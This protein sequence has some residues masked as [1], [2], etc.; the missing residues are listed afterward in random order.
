MSRIDFP[1]HLQ[2]LVCVALLLPGVP[3]LAAD[4]TADPIAFAAVT[5]AEPGSTVISE[6]QTITGIDTSV[7]I[8][9]TGGLYSIN[10]GAFTGAAGTVTS[11]SSVRLQEVASTAFYTSTSTYLRLGSPAVTSTFKVSTRKIDT[12]PDA[13]TFAP[14]SDAALG[15]TQTSDPAT[16]TGLEAA[17]AITVTGGG[18]SIDGGE[19]TTAAGTITNNAVVRARGMAGSAANQTTTVTVKIGGISGAFKIVTAAV[20]GPDTTP[21]AFSFAP[22]ADAAIGST[23]TSEAITVSGINASTP[24]SIVGGSYSINGQ[25]F[26]TAAGSVRNG[27]SVR[28]RQT[29]STS[30]S[31]KTTAVLTIGGVAGSW[32]L[33][34]AALDNSPD[35]IQFQSF[36]NLGP[37]TLVVSNTVTVSGINSAVPISVTGGSYSIDGGAWTSAS[38]T[39][40]N[41]AQVRVQLLTSSAFSSATEAALTISGVRSVFR[42]A[43]VPLE[44]GKDT[45]IFAS[46]AGVAAGALVTSNEVVIAGVNPNSQVSIAGVG[47]TYSINGGPFTREDGVVSN[48]DTVRLRLMISSPAT[49]ATT[50]F[51]VGDLGGSFSLSTAAADTT[52]TAFSLTPN[53]GSDLN[54]DKTKS[55]TV[56][57]INAASPISIEGG[58]YQIGGGAFT[59]E[60]G[61]VNEGQ[62]VTVSL[63]TASTYATDTALRVTI[64]GVSAIFKITTASL[65]KPLIDP[66]NAVYATAQ[67]ITITVPGGIPPG[68]RLYYTTDRSTPTLA[69]TPYTGPFVQSQTGIVRAALLS[70]DGAVTGPVSTR[71]YQIYAIGTTAPVFVSPGTDLGL[72]KIS[73]PIGRYARP[74][75]V[76]PPFV[77]SFSSPPYFQ[78]NADGSI[79]FAAPVTGLHS[80][81]SDDPRS[82]LRQMNADGSLA[83]W[84]VGEYAQTLSA[85]LTVTQVPSSGR[86]VIGQIHAD[87]EGPVLVLLEW[88]GDQGQP[89]SLYLSIR[90]HPDD[91]GR[92]TVLASNVPWGSLVTYRIN[93]SLDGILTVTG[94]GNVAVVPLDPAWNAEGQ[95]FKAGT[96]VLDHEGDASEGG[97]ARFYGIN[98]APTP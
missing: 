54:L 56:R 45:L 38:G 78:P 34:T 59:S 33:T 49:T 52:P 95:Y 10:G 4:T 8:S 19:F 76:D 36:R 81:G 1:V 86:I 26:V 18:Y 70:A 72:W 85:A 69:S 29:A 22:M 6:S 43:N 91:P 73:L 21:N 75:E 20:A 65:P 94:N 88:R 37:G 51:F 30:F 96:Y 24:V 71:D 15:S 9:I 58:T 79:D 28:L 13:F 7:P 97:A 50:A 39:V 98:I 60:P 3:A 83:S 82:E 5:N 63:R 55:F 32:D 2:A 64:G 31:T 46:V 11:G 89:G 61:L 66:L 48:G 68:A 14:R 17:A 62:T 35:P 67:T 90:I 40:S 74:F 41:G 53:I 92:P 16:I 23:Q 93:V 25:A 57:G 27:D 42:V 87:D 77:A 47:G 44:K 12:V 84:H 80:P